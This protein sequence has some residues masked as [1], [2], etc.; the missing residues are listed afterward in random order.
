MTE[1]ELKLFLKH[2][3]K[4]ADHFRENPNSLIAKIFGVFTVE[5][6]RREKVHIL[7]M[8]NVVE[9]QDP[10]NLK[11]LFDLKGSLVNRDV[12]G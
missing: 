9:L 6:E 5:M 2:L 1:S 3:D 10:A 7:L 12:K 11:Y 8:E 4:F